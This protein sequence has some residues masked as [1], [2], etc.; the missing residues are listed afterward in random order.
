MGHL[1]R[2][3]TYKV[4]GNNEGV[5]LCAA[6]QVD[7][8]NYTTQY[9]RLKVKPGDEIVANY[10]ENGHVT[11]DSCP[12]DYKPHAGTYTWVISPLFLIIWNSIDTIV[13]DRDSV[14]W[15]SR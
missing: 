6:N 2:F 5:P 15:R 4:V 1:D 8:N 7:P 3:E 9:P 14:H 13:L 12:P 10:T 11:Q